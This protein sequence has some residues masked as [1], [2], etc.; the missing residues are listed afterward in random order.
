VIVVADRLPA[1]VH[2]GDALALDVHVVS[3]RREALV[4]CAIT[5]VLRWD[6][7][8]ETWRWGGDVP[9]DDC[10]RVGTAPIV[11]PDALGPLTF[12]LTLDGPVHTSNSYETT[13][14]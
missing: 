12:S 7:G 9:A 4:G 8:E 10:V 6:G 13:I 2:P 5:A 3:D 14:A 1:S 11:V